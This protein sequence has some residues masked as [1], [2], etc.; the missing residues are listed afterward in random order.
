M[1]KVFMYGLLITSFLS[2]GSS[3]SGMNQQASKTPVTTNPFGQTYKMPTFEPDTE[4]YF[5][6]TGTATG[7]RERMDILQLD[8]LTNAQNVIRQKMKHAYMGMISDYANSMGINSNG[9]IKAKVERG[10]D[11]IIDVIVEDTQARAIEFSG[12]DEKGNVTCFVGIR[13]MKEQVADKIASQISKDEE[14]KLR[15]DEEQFRKR[16]KEGFKNYKE[17]YNQ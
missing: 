16:I 1:K 7:A 3:K 14:L 10:G 9:D 12:V 11:Q 13:I 2:C 8:A 4:T 5:A 17:N 15:F 6:A